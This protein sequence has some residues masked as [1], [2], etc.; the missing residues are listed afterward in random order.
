MRYGVMD[1][2]V[3]GV[4]DR[5]RHQSAR[6]AARW[7]CNPATTVMMT[8]TTIRM[9]LRDPAKCRLTTITEQTK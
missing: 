3:D 5:H 9:S 6:R 4:R 2:W 8:V 7:Q 1:S